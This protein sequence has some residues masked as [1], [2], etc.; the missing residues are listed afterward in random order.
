MSF[1]RL[2]EGCGNHRWVDLP[3]GWETGLGELGLL[4]KNNRTGT[5]ANTLQGALKGCIRIKWPQGC[6]GH[7]FLKK[8]ILLT[9]WGG[10]KPP[11]ALAAPQQMSTRSSIAD[12][13]RAQGSSEGRAEERAGGCAEISWA[14]GRETTLSRVAENALSRRTMVEQ[15]QNED[16]EALHDL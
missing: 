8:C 5:Q 10:E 2:Q 11:P 16:E 15:I 3:A 14:P 6:S 4:L 7:R 12:S 1:K 13:P 9:C